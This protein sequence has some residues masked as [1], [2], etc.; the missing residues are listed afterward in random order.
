MIKFRKIFIEL[1]ISSLIISLIVHPI[2][3]QSANSSTKSKLITVW[4]WPA[5]DSAFNSVI[6]GFN[7]AYPNV[8]V[9][10][11]MM[12]TAD[13]HNK[14]LSSLAAKAGAPDVSMI[15][16]AQIGKFK[17][18]GGLENLLVKPYN[19]IELKNQFVPYA[20][21]EALTNDN[22][23]IG[24][25]WDIGP[26]TLFYRKDIFKKAGLPT[27][28]EKVAKLLNTWDNFIEAGK[29]IVKSNNKVWMMSNAINLID[30]YFGA[31]SRHNFYD[32][33]YNFILKKDEVVKVLDIAKKI[34]NNKL[35]AKVN[36]WTPE[37]QAMLKDGKIAVE[38][39]GSW[40]GGFLKSWIAPQS[41]GVWGVT[42]VPENAAYNWG[43][44]FLAIP[45]Q[46]KNKN[47]AWSFIK[48]CLADKNSQNTMFK[49]VDYF[50]A[51]IPA[52]D[53]DMYKEKDPYFDNQQTKLL[54]IDIAKK[55]KNIH[56]T[57][58]DPIVA[59]TLNEEATKAINQ[60]INSS[61][62]VDNAFKR[63]EQQTK[64]DIKTLKNQK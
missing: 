43:G 18:T 58:L 14:L 55:I 7:K 60:N 15:E 49:T 24:L 64:Q 6:K 26:C 34:R 56:V 42:Y 41:K 63:I 20:W 1:I 40:F 44:S 46:S 35:D 62:V 27:E 22:R 2:N 53:D 17:S 10:I 31:S 16:N 28:P 3:V 50:P 51:Y 52:W 45:S 21:S 13:V 48:Y 39:V 30:I 54:W 25:P 61:V 36:L 19:A 11:V 32:S 12:A 9:K 33:S 59:Q 29:K 38:I 4:G 5:A 8:K 37:W 23:L 57:K 47:E